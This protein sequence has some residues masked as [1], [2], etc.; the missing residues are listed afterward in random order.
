MEVVSDLTLA[1]NHN[2][3]VAKQVLSTQA[4]NVNGQLP[5]LLQLHVNC[6][7]DIIKQ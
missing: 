3:R 7:K 1:T 6:W 2:E 5:I 4:Y